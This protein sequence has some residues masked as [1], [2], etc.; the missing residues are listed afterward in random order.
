MSKKIFFLILASLNLTLLGQDHRY[1]QDLLPMSFHAK[2]RENLRKLMPKNSVAI[3]FTNP[4]QVRSNDVYYEYHQDPNFFYLTGF[5]EPNS[6]LVIFKDSVQLDSINT[7]ELLFIPPKSQ[8]DELWTGKRLGVDSA[9]NYLKFTHLF[10]NQQFA[11]IQVQFEQFSSILLFPDMYE[12][13]SIDDKYNRGDLASLKKHFGIKTQQVDSLKNVTILQDLM[14]QLREVKSPEEISL[15]Q[16]AIMITCKAQKELMKALLPGKHEYSAEAIVEYVFKEQGAEHPG[17]PSILGGGEN[18]CV[19]HYTSNRKMLDFD[20]LLVSDVGA[21]YHYYTADVTRTM[22]A[23]GKFSEEQKIIYNIVLEAQEAGIKACLKGNKF[24]QPHED[25]KKI[26]QDRLFELGI[27]TEKAQY[28]TYFMHGT[29]HYLGLDVHD[30][31]T[32]QF[33]KPGNVITVEPGIYIP[34][35][36]PCDPKWWNIGIRIE[37][38]ILI[39]EGNPEVLSDCVPKTIAEIEQI[40][41][42]KSLFNKFK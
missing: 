6:V 15:M 2:N 16:N 9:M 30:A 36:S 11:D 23:S 20:D 40:M 32:F 12:K 19:L 5:T 37:D 14:D 26:I 29:S 31:G 10:S 24:W 4:E 35:G 41:S 25:A 3:F 8:K 17:Y 7:Q 42:E 1:D 38:D 33:L 34:E 18:S 39:T 21:E 13:A 27:I 28:K 22:P